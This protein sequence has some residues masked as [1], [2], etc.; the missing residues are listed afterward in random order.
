MTPK[1]LTPANETLDIRP[2]GGRIGAEIHGVTLSGGLPAG[3]VAAIKAALLKYKVLFFRDQDQFNDLEQE[4][5]AGFFGPIHRH[6]T[7]KSDPNAP[8][9]FELDSRRGER[10]NAWH[11]DHTF[12]DSPP[13]GTILRSVISPEIGGDTI[14]SN[15]AAAYDDLPEEI[16]RLAETLWGVHSSLLG[17]YQN[18]GRTAR[19]VS[20]EEQKKLDQIAEYQRA[21][22]ASV[23]ETEHP[24]VR[25]HPE[26]GE[27][28]LLL[29]TFLRGILGYTEE[30]ALPILNVLQ[31]S[32]MRPENFVRWRWRANDV[33]IWDN[34][35]TQHYA[36]Y[37]YGETTRVMRRITIAGEI[38][39]NIFGEPSRAIQTGS[40]MK[41]MVQAAAAE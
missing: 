6:L 12:S 3:I 29:G 31:A 23:Y 18:T 9:I 21:F 27:K 37:D 5:L 7:I 17:G 38:P 26:T 34:R 28:S 11:T 33:V 40:G 32:V 24:I 36:V 15:T 25:V 20:P 4:K 13:L 30:M 14:W 19:P 8:N 39:V 2:I 10:A 1:T 35:S 41:H 16:Q 22:S